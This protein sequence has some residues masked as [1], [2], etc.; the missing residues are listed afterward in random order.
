VN[1]QEAVARGAALLD[2]KGPSDWR[3]R[4]RRNGPLTTNAMNHMDTCVIGRVFGTRNWGAYE[5]A[6]RELG[7]RMEQDG[8]VRH[9]FS[10]SGADD[11]QTE[12]T[13]IAA[14]WNAELGMALVEEGATL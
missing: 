3:E 8:D 13:A 7:V 14:A 9:G 11:W 10:A 1:A 6:L 2:A 5:A 4:V 12:M